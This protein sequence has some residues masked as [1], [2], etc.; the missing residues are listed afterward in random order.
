MLLSREDLFLVDPPYVS[1]GMNIPGTSHVGVLYGRMAMVVPPDLLTEAK[2]TFRKNIA[3]YLE[4]DGGNFRFAG[5]HIDPEDPSPETLMKDVELDVIT[6][7]SWEIFIKYSKSN[8]CVLPAKKATYL[9]S[10]MRA[11]AEGYEETLNAFIK[12]EGQII[13]C[14]D[15]KIN[16]I[17][18]RMNIADGTV[19]EERG[20]G[21]INKIGQDYTEYVNKN[22][23]A[24]KDGK[25]KCDKK[26]K[27]CNDLKGMPVFGAGFNGKFDANSIS[28]GTKGN[29][30]L[31]SNRTAG[32]NLGDGGRSLAAKRKKRLDEFKKK[33]GKNAD[34]YLKESQNNLDDLF[35]SGGL[36]ASVAKN[37][38]AGSMGLTG[39]T[40]PSSR[41]I[42]KDKDKDKK[43]IDTKVIANAGVAPKKADGKSSAFDLDE[44]EEDTNYSNLSDNEVKQI[45]S[46]ADSK[47]YDKAEGDSLWTIV[48]KAYVRSALPI[49]LKKRVKKS[50]IPGSKFIEEENEFSPWKWKKPK[51]KSSKKVKNNS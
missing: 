22:K 29:D 32:G 43:E 47:K 20:D 27:S 44:D 19:I 11:A 12:A 17:R 31:N 18:E 39:P 5:G 48:S 9:D 21:K 24:I 38:G 16:L 40:L 13:K 8:R 6:N 28:I 34:K 15:N 36:L 10:T 7:F 1:T 35:G 14:L 25:I 42:K 45:L 2:K 49:F 50:K 30:N 3:T 51:K 4:A 23:K 41:K 26:K 46:S 33:H 37:P